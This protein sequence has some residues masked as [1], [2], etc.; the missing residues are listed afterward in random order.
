MTIIVYDLEMTVRRKKG[1]IAEII[2]IGAA[3]VGLVGDTPQIID[4]FQSFVRPVIVTQLTEDTTSFTGIT[5]DDVN[6]AGTL[7][8]VLREYT[9]WMGDEEYFLCA[10]GPDD[11]RQLVQECRQ[12]QISTDWIVNHNNLQKM[13]SKIY[14]LEKH[15]QMGLKPALEMLE[16]P[17]SGSHHRAMDD[18]INT[19]QILVKL[20]DQFQFRR[21]KLS[22]EPKFESEVVYKTDH[23]EN[24]PFAGLANLFPEQNK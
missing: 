5:Q 18:A 23:F 6:G 10:W 16:I 4:T 11:Q 1:Q 20:Y 22:D 17:F 15:Q 3:K 19:A 14:K 13:L 12:H 8:E 2:E 7:A 24:L 21:N 9:E